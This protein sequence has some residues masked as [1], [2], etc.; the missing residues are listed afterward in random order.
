MV[1]KEEK[2]LVSVIVPV[3]NTEAYLENSLH[4]LRIQTEERI[5][6]LLI[7]DGS[8]DGSLEICKRFASEDARFRLFSQENQGVSAARNLGLKM[9]QGEY[10]QFMDADDVVEPDFVEKLLSAVRKSD[11]EMAVCA[12]RQLSSEDGQLMEH[13]TLAEG[14]Y[15]TEAYIR[16][17]QR[18]PVAHV[19][20]VLWNKIYLGRIIRQYALQFDTELSLGEDFV[21]NMQYLAYCNKI[22]II[23]DQLY[24]YT[25][26]RSG[27]L[28]CA[29]QPV[30]REIQKRAKLYGAYR[31]L[32]SARGLAK[33][34]R[35][36]MVFY[37]VKCYFDYLDEH[38]GLKPDEKKRLYEGIIL[39]NGISR[40][41]YSVYWLI[42]KAKHAV[43]C[44]R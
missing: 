11:S 9:A 32:Y 13:V 14:A 10:L 33:K 15:S 2:P 3:Y 42:K 35:F 37:D 36:W 1:E 34:Q 18:K 12:F 21:F 38:S 24:H 26:K 29:E 23:P 8:T 6:I 40:A 44:L 43:N 25:W 17:I 16:L 22:T 5:E 7:N 20:G 41:E 4:S 31:S 30:K 28:D 19:I 39:D 27:S